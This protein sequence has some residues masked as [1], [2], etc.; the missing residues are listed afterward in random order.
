MKFLV[1]LL[2]STA[3][4]ACDMDSMTSGGGDTASAEFTPNVSV[5]NIEAHIRFLASDYMGGRD[6]GSDGFEIAANYVAS[7]Y[8]LLGL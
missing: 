2:A 7:Q 4:V 3:L 6:T 8:R 5:E 1:P